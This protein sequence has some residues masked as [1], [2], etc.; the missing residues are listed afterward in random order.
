MKKIILITASKK[1]GKFYETILYKV[2]QDLVEIEVVSLKEMKNYENKKADL[3]LTTSL[4][5]GLF[6]K[7]LEKIHEKNKIILLKLTIPL[8]GIEKINKIPY[9]SNIMLVN[10]NKYTVTET[11]STLNSLGLTKINYYPIYPETGIIPDLDTAIILGNR[12]HIP[13]NVKNIIDIGPRY[14]SSSTI[15]EIIIK[16]GYEEL[17]ESV[18]YKEYIQKLPR[19]DYVSRDFILKNIYIENRF[20]ILIESL[21]TGVI[22]IDKNQKIMAINSYGKKI[23]GKNDINNFVS[24]IL[25]KIDFNIDKTDVNLLKINGIYLNIFLNPININGIHLGVFIFFQKFLVEEKKQNILRTKLLNKGYI[26]K[27]KFQDIVGTSDIIIKTKNRAEKMAKTDFSI[28]LTGESGTGKELFAHSI[29]NSSLRKNK[30][31]IAINCAA[32]PENLLES[33]LFGYVKGAFTGA[34]KD[35]KIGLFEYAHKGTL[36][37]DEIEGMTQRLQIKLLRVLQEKEIMRV[38]GSEIIK[39]DVRIIAACNENLRELV[40]EGKFR[41]DLYYRLNNLP[42]NIPPLRERKED[43]FVLIEYFKKNIDAHFIFSEEVYEVLKN[44]RWDGNIRELKNLVEY[45]SFMDLNIIEVQ[46]LPEYLKEELLEDNTSDCDLENSC[47]ESI[48]LLEEISKNKKEIYVFI[49]KELQKSKNKKE[50]IGRKKI[51]EK[52]EE[53]GIFV[54][55][56]ETRKILVDLDKIKLICVSKGRG[57][58]KITSLGE[59]ILEYL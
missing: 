43:I 30:A 21:D 17:F 16:L 47:K 48:R 5:T 49:L 28:L 59:N 31:F 41:K 27:Y 14:L 36:F 56:A 53:K 2:L 34:D 19:T 26:A 8:S 29:H 58:S 45:M 12:E 3:Y 11:I 57:G 7:I 46:D 51:I 13:K 40:K 4:S 50:L 22:G 1:A 20:N 15:A 54:T 23:I 39:L 25:K 44:Y 18:G 33:E 32:L 42:I 55:E 24:E 9:G 38:G 35:G 37:L 52:A 10:T 6:D